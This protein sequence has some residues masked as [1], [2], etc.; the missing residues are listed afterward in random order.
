MKMNDGKRER[1]GMSRTT[2]YNRD[3]DNKNAG[4]IVLICS[5]I[6]GAGKT[7]IT[8]NLAMLLVKQ[9]LKTVIVDGNL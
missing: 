8:A 7:A 2:E 5:A 1:A 9:N 3:T 6:G 4:K